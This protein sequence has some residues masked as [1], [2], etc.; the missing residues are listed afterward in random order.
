MTIAVERSA[1]VRALLNAGLTLLPVP[2]GITYTEIEIARIE[3]TEK[4]GMHRRPA[5]AVV[6]AVKAAIQVRR[7]RQE[8][9]IQ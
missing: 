4:I 1:C 9:T 3:R 6:E 2:T 5:A 7:Y 8:G